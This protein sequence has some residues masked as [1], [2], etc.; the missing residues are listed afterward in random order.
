MAI[1]PQAAIEPYDIALLGGSFPPG[2]NTAA[3]A[4]TLDPSETPDGYGYDLTKDGVIAKAAIPSASS[5]TLKSVTLTENAQSIPYFW[6]YNRLWN[7]TNRTVSTA[8]NILTYGALN[9]EDIFVKQRLGKIY[10]DEDTNTIVAIQ[11]FGRDSMFVAKGSGA[12]VISGIA[13]TR[14]F[15]ATTHLIEDIELG[16][17]TGILAMNGVV[18]CASAN[19]LYAYDGQ[20]VTE[21]TRKVRDDLTNFGNVA[22]TGDWE[23]GYVKGGT[24]YVYEPATQKLFRWDGTNFRYTTRQLTR[25]NDEPFSVDNLLITVNHTDTEAGWFKWQVKIEDEAWSGEE[26]ATVPYDEGTYTQFKLF[27]DGGLARSCRKFQFRMTDLASNLQ[28]KEIRVD[29]KE[30]QQDDYTQ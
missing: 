3:P 18:Y 5:R 8:S 16:G 27:M 9:Y 24:S 22:L 14:A 21:I 23:K 29:S 10:F 2:L 11:P 7:I 12:Y 25:R 20:R 17:A 15:W 1:R 4:D 30:F 6:A 19:G 26:T 13:D 28:I